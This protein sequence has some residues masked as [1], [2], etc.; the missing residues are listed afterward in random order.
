MTRFIYLSDTHWGV[1]APGYTMQTAQPNEL[2]QL[3]G[4]LEA[5]I[6][7]HAPIDFVLHG[8]DMI[9][10]TSAENIGRVAELFRL[11]VP[12][13]LCLGNHDLTRADAVDMW[14]DLAPHFFIGG[15]D[16]ALETPDCLLHVVP[17]QWGAEPYFW[18]GVQ[19]PHFLPDQEQ[20]LAA[21]LGRDRDKVHVLSTHS[22]FFGVPPEQTGFDAPF[23]QPPQS[24]V[25][26]GQALFA[27]HAHL[28]CV[29]GAHSHINTCVARADQ[30]LVTSSSFV[31]TPFDFK[32]IHIAD[33]HLSM[34]THSLAGRIDLPASYDYEKTFVQGRACDRLI[35]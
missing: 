18:N 27:A 6:E 5:W 13:Y 23:H 7:S 31:E 30:Y 2:S 20:S 19:E 29:L 17:N 3:L 10:S 14:L 8:G 12:V 28:R 35:V 25:D 11:S 24:F 1:D 26:C 15:P 33:G 22:P 32:C 34:A 4:A 9:D 21:G 16:F